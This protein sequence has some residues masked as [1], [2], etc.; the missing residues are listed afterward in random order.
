M[1]TTL[2]TRVN[3]KRKEERKGGTHLKGDTTRDAEPCV[4][5]LNVIIFLSKINSNF[6]T[7][8]DCVDSYIY[9]NLYYIYSIFEFIIPS[10]LFNFS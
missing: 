2:N 10:I 8:V 7:F 4:D 3:S 6:L 1:G 5:T 9:V